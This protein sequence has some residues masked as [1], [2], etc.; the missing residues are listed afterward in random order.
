MAFTYVQV[1]VGNRVFNDLNDAHSF[2]VKSLAQSIDRAT[3]KVSA[4]L[5]K[6]INKIYQK[7]E[8][9]NSRPW[10]GSFINSGDSLFRRSGQ[11]LRSILT[12]IKS[13]GSGKSTFASFAIRGYMVDQ[14]LGAVR[15]PTSSKYLTIPFP[16]ALNA[17]GVPIHRR[18]RDWDNTFVARS[19]GGS[20]L[21][22]QKGGKGITPLYLLKKSVRI[23]PRLGAAKI[24][25]DE[26]PFF[27]RRAFEAFDKELL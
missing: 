3:V 1:K 4:Q 5:L 13:G 6:T 19:S 16:A 7:I 11:G 24:V 17:Q 18:A 2:L 20:L 27:E 15:R 21:I 12:S 14:E 8:A 25:N 10:D 23:K 9:K 26:L 22:F